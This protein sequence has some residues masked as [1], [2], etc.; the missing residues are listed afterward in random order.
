MAKVVAVGHVGLNARDLKALADFY[1]EVV[2]LRPVAYHQGVVAIFA[3]G[4][5]QTDLF[6]APGEPQPVAFDLGV[7]DV[8]GFRAELL[9]AGVACGETKTDKVTSHRGFSFRDPEGNEIRVR[10]AH[11]H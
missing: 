10:D 3:V 4:D 1:R 5:T 6:L 9:S 7:D 2:G 8:D 11:R